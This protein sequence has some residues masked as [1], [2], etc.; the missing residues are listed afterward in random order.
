MITLELLSS[1]AGTK[2]LPIVNHV[3]NRIERFVYADDVDAASIG[4]E[5]VES[6]EITPAKNL[7][8]SNRTYSVRENRPQGAESRVAYDKFVGNT[9]ITEYWD[10]VATNKTI[11]DEQGLVKPLIWRHQLRADVVDVSL[12]VVSN[13]NR[14][15]VDTGYVVD[16]AG[17]NIYTNYQNFFN[18]NSGTHRLYYVVSTDV[19][20]DAI[21]ELLNP[22]PVAKEASWEDYDIVTAGLTTEYPLYI[23]ER[24]VGGNTFTF[25]GSGPWYVRQVSRSLIQPLPPMAL[26]ASDD[27]F[28][29]F[30]NGDV[31]AVVNAAQRRYYI[32]EFEKQPFAPTKPYIY[33]VYANLDLVNSSVLKA[34]RE[35]LAVIPGQPLT[36][37]IY[38]YDDNL[39][40]VLTNDATLD[41]QRYN[42]TN[43]FYESDKIVSVD[44]AGGFISLGIKLLP[45]WK[46]QA[47]Y[48][49]EAIDFEYNL[50]DL[51][52][53]LNDSVRN[54]IIVFYCVPDADVDGRAIQHLVVDQNGEIVD[55]SQN[56]YQLRVGGAPNPDTLIGTAY[57]DFIEN[58]SAAGN[59]AFAYMLLAEVAVDIRG[60][61]ENSTVY[62]V[63]EQG[64]APVDDSVLYKN[65]RILQSEI[66]GREDGM[67]VPK[68]KV[69]IFELPLSIRD[70]YGGDLSEAQAVALAKRHLESTVYPVIRWTY[71]HVD[72]SATQVT[73]GEADVSFIWEGPAT[74]R[75]YRKENAEDSWVE[76]DSVVQVVEPVDRTVIFS[77]TGLTSGVYYYGVAMEVDG[78][79]FPIPNYVSVEV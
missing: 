68:N 32:P 10:I 66:L 52:P 23:R 19:N 3:H 65:P 59:N 21:R 44:N 60:D 62:D 12:E 7:R 13:G 16:L 5:Y 38:D 70:D 39:L 47:Q 73:A 61:F 18:P 77:D 6:E 79:L 56:E 72:I 46:F 51:N 33:S 45:S 64:A 29:R 2:T 75:L 1:G 11:V 74:Y 55:V 69:I 15:E 14:V 58:Y 54:R 53:V 48:Y 35:S 43:V 42:D 24:G 78:L 34:P 20:G 76:I 30:S 25:N 67:V 9:Y 40:R 57:A 22:V 49:Y 41:G 63:R 50:I 26:D 37:F 27:W 71:P 28:I 17:K 36:I 8:I 4:L 31:Q